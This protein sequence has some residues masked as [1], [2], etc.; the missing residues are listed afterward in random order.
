MADGIR[1]SSFKDNIV[2]VFGPINELLDKCMD[3]QLFLG[4][5][6]PPRYLH[7]LVFTLYKQVFASESHLSW[8]K[9]AIEIF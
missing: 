6:L 9:L 8:Y 1:L 2:V 3:G 5:L 4:G 7:K